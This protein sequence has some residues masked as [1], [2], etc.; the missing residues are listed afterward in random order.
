[1]T[2]GIKIDIECTGANRYSDRNLYVRSN[3]LHICWVS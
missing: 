2:G 3:E 1:M